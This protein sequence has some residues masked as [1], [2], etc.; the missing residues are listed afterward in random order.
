MIPLDRRYNKRSHR[1]RVSRVRHEV[2]LQR[3]SDGRAKETMDNFH[4]LSSTRKL[5]L[6]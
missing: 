4:P 5:R 3:A 6:R 2:A 1:D